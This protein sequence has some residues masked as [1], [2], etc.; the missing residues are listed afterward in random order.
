[1]N[2]PVDLKL[3]QVPWDQ[4][5]DVVLKTN[6]ITY[7][8]DGLVVRVMSRE[9][10]TKELQDEINQRKASQQAPDLVLAYV[11]LNYASAVA[12]KK[13]LEQAR[14]LSE[15]GSVDVEERTNMLILRDVPQ[16]LDEVKN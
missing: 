10:R 2:A 15:R 11:R 13:L 3:T 12:M 14:V 7:Q 5:L 1:V 9:A 16:F 6:S 8:M 4:V